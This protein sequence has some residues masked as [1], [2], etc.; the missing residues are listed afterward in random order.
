MKK[1]VLNEKETQYL[2]EYGCVKIVRNGLDICVEKDEDYYNG[3]RI[4]IIN[5]YDKVELTE[6]KKLA[7]NEVYGA[8]FEPKKY[9][10]YDVKTSGK[11]PIHIIDGGDY[12]TED[13]REFCGDCGWFWL[14]EKE[15]Q[16]YKSQVKKIVL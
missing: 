11:H 10:P 6:P 13:D 5:P 1:L 3:Y 7:I 4:A 14:N 9:H 15:Y 12:I 8:V 16:Y 2:N